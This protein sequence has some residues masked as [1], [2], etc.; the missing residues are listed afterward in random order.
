MAPIYR[1]PTVG[2]PRRAESTLAARRRHLVDVW[3]FPLDTKVVQED[4]VA[5]ALENLFDPR[6]HLLIV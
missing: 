6:L 5:R 2:K 1:G 3:S 4:D